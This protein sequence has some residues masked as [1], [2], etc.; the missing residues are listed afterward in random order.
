MKFVCEVYLRRALQKLMEKTHMPSTTI[1]ACTKNIFSQLIFFHILTHFLRK[2]ELQ[3]IDRLVGRGGDYLI[4]VGYWYSRRIESSTVLITIGK[5]QGQHL[6]FQNPK[7]LNGI[8]RYWQPHNYLLETYLMTNKP[9][10]TRTG[11]YCIE[12]CLMASI[13]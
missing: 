3:I 13:V 4:H 10:N 11:E 7:K 6:I 5:Q 9:N 12:P 2:N 8:Q 1:C